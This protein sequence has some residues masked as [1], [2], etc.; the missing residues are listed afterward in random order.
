MPTK[1]A[2][3]LFT[4]EELDVNFLNFYFDFLS[5]QNSNVLAFPALWVT[6]FLLHP[7]FKD[8]RSL[9]GFAFTKKM[10]MPWKHS[11]LESLREL[12]VKHKYNIA[13][14]KV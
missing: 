7:T 8:L 3:Q 2:A 14:L 6:E 12:V 10:Q 11:V 1:I 9:K 4:N 5:Q 13:S